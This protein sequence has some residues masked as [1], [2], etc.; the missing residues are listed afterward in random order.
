[1][2]IDGNVQ[3]Y[4]GCA[5]INP[6]WSRRSRQGSGRWCRVPLPTPT[7]RA[8]PSGLLHRCVFIEKTLKQEPTLPG[9]IVS[10]V[11]PRSYEVFLQVPPEYASLK[12]AL[13]VHAVYSFNFQPLFI[14]PPHP[15]WAH[16]FLT[17][18]HPMSTNAVQWVQSVSK[19]AGF[20]F[21]SNDMPAWW[22]DLIY[23]VCM[24]ISLYNTL[25]IKRNPI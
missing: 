24:R 6:S 15:P 4:A 5:D 14:C 21:N 19:L 9:C 25:T 8:A 3:N 7:L 18:T 11:W 13:G 23:Q 12:C 1:M 2:K 16:V 17:N 10:L 20:G 22:T